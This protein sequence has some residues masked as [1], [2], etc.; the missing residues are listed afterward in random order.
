MA[1]H[2]YT[3]QKE[4]SA[5]ERTL[6]PDLAVIEGFSLSH[7][8]RRVNSGGRDRWGAGWPPA[9]RSHV[10]RNPKFDPF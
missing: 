3:L 2:V 7:Q 8:W 6:V 4:T 10:Y 1:L 5:G 9:L